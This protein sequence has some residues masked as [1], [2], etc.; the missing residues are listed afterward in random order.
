MTEPE[1][2]R[3]AGGAGTHVFRA[4]AVE[5]PSRFATDQRPGIALLT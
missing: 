2:E 5:L 3:F 4:G 1:A